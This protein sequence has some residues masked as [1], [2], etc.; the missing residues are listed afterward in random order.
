MYLVGLVRMFEHGSTR[1]LQPQLVLENAISE[2]M[3]TDNLK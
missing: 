3:G 2:A 1:P